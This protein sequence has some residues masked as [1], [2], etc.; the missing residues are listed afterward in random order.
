MQYVRT[1][2]A[3]AGITTE[4]AALVTFGAG[5][6]TPRSRLLAVGLA[7]GVSLLLIS[8][9]WVRRFVAQLERRELMATIQL[10]IMLAIVLPLLPDRPIDPWNAVSPRK[11]GLFVA[12]IAGINFLGYLLS[13]VLGARRGAGLS[14][15]VGGLASSTAVT[16]AMAQR[17]RAADAMITPGQLATFLANVVMFGRVL[18]VTA[19]LHRGVAAALLAPMLAMGGVLLAGAA[20]KWR[21]LR[22]E[23]TTS[24]G[25]VALEN[26]FA[27]LPA[28]K[29]GGLLAIIL[30]AS[31]VAR[32]EFGSRGLL[33]AAAVSGFADV[34]AINVAVS[35]QAARGDLP[36]SFAALAITVAVLSNTLVKG[37]I[38]VAS[39]GW[40]FGR[41]VALAFVLAMAAGLGAAAL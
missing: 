37:G 33:V 10:A 28:L 22:R 2:R 17:A 25:Q 14:G 18:V 15:I 7:I 24:D 8:K 34:D 12:L 16:A 23:G 1:W 11:V 35:R 21:A 39:G 30:V 19:L 13:R 29:W 3:G 32:A 36:T 38:A 9:P 40:R 6:L 27:L 31:A 4:V 26:P 20:W 5:L 41:D